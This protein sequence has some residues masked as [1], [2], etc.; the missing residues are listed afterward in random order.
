[1]S[2]LIAPHSA[3]ATKI[4]DV[5]HLK[6]A[7][8]NRLV[9]FGLV[10]GL[11]GKGDGG[12]YAPA[13][14]PLAQVLGNFSN[15]TQLEELK[16]TRNVALVNL[17]RIL[18]E[19]GVREGDSLDV[20]VTAIGSAKSLVGGRLFISPLQ[21]PNRADKRIFALAGGAIQVPDPIAPTRAV[22][23]GGATMER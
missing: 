10:T 6:G 5:T 8:N 14:R 13:I 22:V 3:F 4:G 23:R 1:C 17:E 20:H 16:D 11:N 21:G 7:R 9:G 2:L 18:P 12:K 15:P 19:H